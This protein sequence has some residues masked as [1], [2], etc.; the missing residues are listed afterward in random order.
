M[1][2]KMLNWFCVVSKR[3]HLGDTKWNQAPNLRPTERS[4]PGRVLGGSRGPS[5]AELRQMGRHLAEV[6]V[7]RR[8]K[9]AS[10]GI[11]VH[12][13]WLS[14]LPGA[15]KNSWGPGWDLE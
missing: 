5:L 14:E 10:F 15:G 12:I 8:L 4:V 9:Q 2:G 6:C 1:T 11:P 3:Q 7:A 13:L